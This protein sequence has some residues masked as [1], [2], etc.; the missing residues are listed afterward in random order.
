VRQL[1]RV[2][3]Q[4]FFKDPYFV[5]V[6]L[7]DRKSAALA[8]LTACAE[9]VRSQAS[10]EPSIRSVNW[11]TDDAIERALSLKQTLLIS[12]FEYRVYFVAPNSAFDAKWMEAEDSDG[13]SVEAASC[14]GKKVY[15]CLFPALFQHPVH[16]LA[17]DADVRCALVRYK[18]FFP[19]REERA[20]LDTIDVIAKAVVYVQ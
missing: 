17:E 4:L 13:R 6:V 2:T 3:S 20:A 18:R 10:T 14:I 15:M 5:D 7:R 19:T 12:S 9:T 8:S 11:M 16:R 1:D